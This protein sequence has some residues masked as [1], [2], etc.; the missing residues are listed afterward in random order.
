MTLLPSVWHWE[1]TSSRLLGSQQ[2]GGNTQLRS[3]MVDG[4][5]CETGR[6][7]IPV[8]TGIRTDSKIEFSQSAWAKAGPSKQHPDAVPF[9]LGQIAKNPREITLIAIAPLTNIGAAIDKDPQ[10]FSK[11]KRIVLMGGS[12]RRGY[13]SQSSTGPDAEYNIRS[14]IAAARKLL[15]SGV[16]IYL[17][18][19]DSTMIPLDEVMREQLFTQSTPLTDAL[20]LLYQQWNQSYRRVTPTLFDAVPVAYVIQPGLCPTTALHISV[21]D[22]GFTREADGPTNVQACLQSD[23]QRLLQFYMPRLLNARF[24]GTEQCR[25]PADTK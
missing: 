7:Q 16:P 12:I 11:L 1:A 25:M 21:D 24:S 14:D 6:S 20:T 17:M 8:A 19:L 13:D 23:P 18:P 9:L 4:L 22:K 10:T 3:Q 2:H 5:L 15:V